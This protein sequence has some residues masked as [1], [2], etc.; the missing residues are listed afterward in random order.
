MQKKEEMKIYIF[1][2][3]EISFQLCKT[4]VR[5]YLPKAPPKEFNTFKGNLNGLKK[6]NY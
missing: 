2:M 1:R 5:K 3:K 6:R 4:R